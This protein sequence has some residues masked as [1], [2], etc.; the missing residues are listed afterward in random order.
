MR[1]AVALALGFAWSATAYG[2]PVPITIAPFAGRC[3]D[4]AA[5]AERVRA[6]AEAPVRIGQP[7]RGS[8][9]LVH[10]SETAAQ[11][12]IDFTARDER[13]RIVGSAHRMVPA[14][15][16]AAALDVAAL[17][18]ARAAMPLNVEPT[19]ERHEPRAP[20]HTPPPQ[21]PSPQ[22][23]PPQSPPPSPPPAAA[24]PIAPPATPSPPP[25]PQVIII[26]RVAP[27]SQ[28]PP[29]TILLR[30]RGP[31][32]RLV[33]E[34]VAA[35]YGAFGIDGSGADEPAGELSLGLRRGRFGVAIRG[36]V[37][38]GYTV[39]APT[40]AHVTL[41]LRRAEV[42]LEAHLDVP[43][44]VGALRFVLGPA[45]PLWSVRPDGV[46]HPQPSIIASVA[47]TAR[48]LYHLD[49]GRIFLTAGVTCETSLLRHELTVTGVGAVA[50]TPLFEV[51]PIL[52]FGVNL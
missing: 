49:L 43:I 29:G 23:P 34:L 42:A 20:K 36:A 17:I 28:P 15:D 39:A 11:V 22:S 48:I 6:R 3:F 7:P 12:R 33:G 41:Q 37:E 8:H 46:P 21:S 35:V 26:E 52:G 9:Q 16:C 14:G 50:R 38:G 24:E 45:V 4:A 18:V 2:E 40:D 32:R 27:P 44:R 51:G 10:V 1:L 13:G 47:V 30:T 19:A 31:E 25:K 5:L